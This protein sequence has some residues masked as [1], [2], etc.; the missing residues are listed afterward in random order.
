MMWGKNAVWVVPVLVL[1]AGAVVQAAPL[2]LSLLTPD[3]ASAWL[4]VDYNAGSDLLTATGFAMTFDSDG[5]APPDENITSGF[6]DI[7][8]PVDLNGAITVGVGTLT[9]SGLVASGGPSLLTGDIVAFG[10]LDGGG[11]IFEFLFD[12]TGGDLA[13]NFGSQVGV[14]VDAWDSG[15]S[16]SFDSGFSNSGFGVSDTGAVPEPGTLGMFSFGVLALWA[17]RR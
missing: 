6:F 1:M 12:V 15:F 14:I 13:G 8:L 2:N 9:I 11:E 17:S 16:G 5:V 4:T 3:I 10:Y 7:S